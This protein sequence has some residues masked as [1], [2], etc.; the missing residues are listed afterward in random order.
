MT[1]AT[2]HRLA[3]VSAPDP[4]H[5]GPPVEP[6]VPAPAAETPA[7]RRPRLL[8][9]DGLR[10]GAA[11]MVVA[12][13]LVGDKL[14]AWQDPSAGAI[15]G[16]VHAVAKYGFLGVQLFFIISGF[17]ICMSAWGRTVG[18]FFVSRVVRLYPAY[19]FAVLLATGVLLL[20]PREGRPEPRQV[21][22]NLTM[23][24]DFLGIGHLDLSYWTLTVEMI[25]YL[26]FAILVARGLSYR[27]VVAFCAL[28]TI[29]SLV[30]PKFGNTWLIQVTAANHS[31]YF[32]AG[33]ALYLIHRFG[34]NLLLWSIV[35]LSGLVALTRLPGL[36]RAREVGY[37]P[38]AVIVVFFL[39]LMA[40]VALGRFGWVRW[41]W[42]ATAGALTYPLYLIHQ[43]LG[44]A[45]IQRAQDHLSPWLL[46]GAVFAGLLLAAWLIHRFVE[47]PVARWM[48]PRLTAAVRQ[49]REAR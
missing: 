5:P 31:S 25:F 38:S 20:V 2:D 33:V 29:G 32:I 14:G 28:W 8:V 19:W 6:A 36:A 16:P 15:F 17:V 43:T 21:L 27:G 11:V 41:S 40:A 22:G 34:P 46:I 37:L 10:L 42:V 4:A 30:V 7:P 39:A 47:R 26:L 35:G 3:P 13:H 1:Q 45:L 49:A 12:Y 24:Q 18:D 48:K 9:L 23:M 44:I